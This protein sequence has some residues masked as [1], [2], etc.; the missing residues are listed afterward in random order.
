[1]GYKIYQEFPPSQLKKKS[2]FFL[3]LTPICPPVP[4]PNILLRIAIFAAI[5]TPD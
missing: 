1:V 5:P 3:E 4:A 2:S